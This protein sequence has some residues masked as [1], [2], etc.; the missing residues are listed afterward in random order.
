MLIVVSSGKTVIFT[1]AS[2]LFCVKLSVLIV[3]Y[4]H[5]ITYYVLIVVIKNYQISEENKAKLIQVSKLGGGQ[6]NSPCLLS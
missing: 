4:L 1:L 2:V 6:S 5:C 3:Y